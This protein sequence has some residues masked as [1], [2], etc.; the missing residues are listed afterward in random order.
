VEPQAILDH[1]VELARQAGIDVRV[2]T[3]P[4]AAGEPPPTS[5]VC[6]VRGALWIVLAAADPVEDRIGVV[7]RVLREHAGAV[8]E[9]RYLPPAVRD[10]LEAPAGPMPSGS[11]CA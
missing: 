4:G 9:E 1:L 3:G 6:R 8:L 7:V 10:R 5:A 11:D 2:L